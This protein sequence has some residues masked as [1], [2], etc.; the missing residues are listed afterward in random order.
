[1]TFK[2]HMLEE[3]SM[4]GRFAGNSWV[5]V[6]TSHRLIRYRSVEKERTSK[7]SRTERME[8]V[9]L[10]E[11]SSLRFSMERETTESATLWPILA[12]LLGVLAL[13]A[14]LGIEEEWVAAVGGLVIVVG[15]WG[16]IA[17]GNS[18]ETEQGSNL[19]I[20][21]SGVLWDSP[22]IV[23]TNRENI[24]ELRE[25]TKTVRGAV[26]DTER[27]TDTVPAMVASE[28]EE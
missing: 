10:S 15:I 4:M 11:I 13:L 9:S 24:D 12:I 1:V 21:G 6:C 27:K 28:D 14:G 19:Q 16:L 22:W 20:T 7:S 17:S 3:E 5:W 26:S 23:A 2:D 25:F 8:D 18:T